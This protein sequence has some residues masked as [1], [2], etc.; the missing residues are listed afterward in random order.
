MTERHL[1]L[2]PS[3]GASGDMLLGTLIGLGAPLP[4]V[5]RQLESLDIPGWSLRESTVTRCSLTATRVEVADGGGHGD[6]NGHHRHPHHHDEL[7][8]HRAWSS[9][10]R[11]LAD[12]QLVPAVSTGARATFRRLAEVEADIHGVDI[13]Q[14]HFHEVGAVDAIVDIVGTWIALD[15]LDVSSV[16]A[17]PIG[18]GSGTVTAAHGELPVPAP[19]TAALLLGAPVRSLGVHG[20][21]GVHGDPGNDLGETVTPTGAGL[22]STMVDGWGPMPSGVLRATARGAGGRDPADHP[23]VLSGYLVEALSD[24]KIGVGTTDNDNRGRTARTVTSTL[25]QTNVDDVSGEIVA[26]TIDRCL[27]FGADDA[28]ARPIVMKKGRPGVELHVL[29]RPELAESLRRL[30]LAETGSLGSRTLSV[31]KHELPRRFETVMVDD[32]AISIKVGPH[33]AKPEFDDVVA[34]ARALELPVREVARLA[35][36][37][38]HEAETGHD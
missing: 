7:H 28:W 33:G 35:L 11:L 38:F 20:H 21:P 23:N 9:I 12:A 19:A 26:Y 3:F 17:G 30:V 6:P 2:D 36:D 31:T 10:D 27:Q 15:L 22:L 4:D 13:D 8:R 32:H 1:W 37:L 25:I 16:S 34:A 18:M 5:V 24:G 29:C 14:V